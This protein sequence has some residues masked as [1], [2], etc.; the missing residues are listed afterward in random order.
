MNLLVAGPQDI[1][2][3]LVKEE[4]NRLTIDADDVTL[5]SDQPISFPAAHKWMKDRWKKARMKG[6]QRNAITKFYYLE[7]RKKIEQSYKELWTDLVRASEMLVVFYDT[8]NVD[9]KTKGILKLAELFDLQ[10]HRVLL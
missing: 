2:Y 4:L 8:G 6:K 7:E 1:D 5:I 9:F 10:T 3:D